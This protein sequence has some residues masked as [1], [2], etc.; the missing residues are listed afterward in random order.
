MQYL[1]FTPGSADVENDPQ[2]KDRSIFHTRSKDGT[3]PLYIFI[4]VV[5]GICAFGSW[6]RRF[7]AGPAVAENKEDL[8]YIQEGW[9]LWSE[10]IDLPWRTHIERWQMSSSS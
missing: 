8:T 10:A 5:C 4:M 1:R 2:M 3:H 6:Q 9:T 7:H